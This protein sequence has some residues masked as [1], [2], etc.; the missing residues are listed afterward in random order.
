[1]IQQLGFIRTDLLA[2]KHWCR[3]QQATESPSVSSY[4]PGRFEKWFDLEFKLST[5]VEIITAPHDERIYQLGQLL[6]PGNHSCL[7][8]HY[9][10]GV[11]ILPHRDHT[12]SEAWVVSINIGARVIFR[13]GN[14]VRHLENG[15]VVGFNSK[16][17]HS[18]DPVKSER[19]ALSWRRIKPQ[20]LHQQQVLF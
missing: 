17:I 11:E 14:E 18:L 12:A 16:V 10:P 6:Y 15:Q 9:L 8:L 13:H 2:L 1:M 5:K 3:K 4:A 19:W 20:Y 7:F